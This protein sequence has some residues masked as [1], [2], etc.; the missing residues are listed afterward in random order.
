MF[1]EINFGTSP[2]H[3]HYNISHFAHVTFVSKLGRVPGRAPGWDASPL[4]GNARIKLVILIYT[5]YESCYPTCSRMGGG[6]GGDMSQGCSNPTTLK[7]SPLHLP[8][9][10]HKFVLHVY[11]GYTLR[12]REH[13]IIH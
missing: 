8:L 1:F 3:R 2:F 12:I 4:Q 5:P 11:Y 9:F 7:I 13:V 6:G 10:L